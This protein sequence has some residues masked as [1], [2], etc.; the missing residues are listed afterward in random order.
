MHVHD[1]DVIGTTIP[2]VWLNGGA[3]YRQMKGWFTPTLSTLVLRQ[4]LIMGSVSENWAGVNSS[5]TSADAFLS[6][7]LCVRHASSLS[8]GWRDV[9]RN[10][11]QGNVHQQKLSGPLLCPC[12]T[13]SVRHHQVGT[14]EVELTRE[15][16]GSDRRNKVFSLFTALW[17][18]QS[19]ITAATGDPQ[20]SRVA[21]RWPNFLHMRT[22]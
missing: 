16:G 8:L 13:L 3:H 18:G 11:F 15:T 19:N 14:R 2:S 20:C 5:H 7:A 6:L 22:K 4:C 1:N 21:V 10:V 9:S 12:N 17:Y